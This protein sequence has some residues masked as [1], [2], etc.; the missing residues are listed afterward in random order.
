MEIQGE[1]QVKTRQGRIELLSGKTKDIRPSIA[2]S[3][4]NLEKA[5]NRLSPE[6]PEDQSPAELLEFYQCY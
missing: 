1:N 5:K 2:Y 4:W 6:L 3:E